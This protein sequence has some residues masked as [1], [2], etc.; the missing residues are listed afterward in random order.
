MYVHII[1]TESCD[2]EEGRTWKDESPHAPTPGQICTYVLSPILQ[3][4]EEGV[5]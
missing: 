5:M 1:Y 3:S 4:G 2:F